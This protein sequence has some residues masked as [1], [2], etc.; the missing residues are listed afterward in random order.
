MMG[1]VMA[2]KRL[3]EVKGGRK[4]IGRRVLGSLW[5]VDDHSG[6]IITTFSAKVTLNG[7]LVRESPQNPLNSGLGII[8]ICPEITW[9]PEV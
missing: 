7:G 9:H 6:Q 4:V 1:D 5:A 8:L 3:G 2:T